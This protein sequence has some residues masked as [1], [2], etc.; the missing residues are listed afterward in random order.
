MS[1]GKQW[2]KALTAEKHANR[3]KDFHIKQGYSVEIKREDRK[4]EQETETLVQKHERLRK[5][6]GDYKGNIS[7]E[8]LEKEGFKFTDDEKIRLRLITRREEMI[9]QTPFG[10]TF[11]GAK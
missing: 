1:Y 7:W 5:N 11:L 3:I 9:V 10:I 2:Q 6:Y 8:V 4:V